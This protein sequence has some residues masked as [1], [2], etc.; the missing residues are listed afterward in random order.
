MF[1]YVP[2][3]AG[4]SRSRPAVRAE[5]LFEAAPLIS[6]AAPR[7][8]KHDENKV[9]VTAESESK[10]GAYGDTTATCGTCG[11]I[12]VAISPNPQGTIFFI[13]NGA[14]LTIPKIIEDQR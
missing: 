1:P 7:L 11:Y 8:K 12:D 2:V 4:F 13:W 6:P 10:A 3:G 9:L 5:C 14:L